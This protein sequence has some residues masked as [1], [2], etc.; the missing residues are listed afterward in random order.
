MNKRKMQKNQTVQMEKELQYRQNK[1]QLTRCEGDIYKAAMKLKPGIVEAERL[2]NHGEAI[3]QTRFYSSLMGIHDRVSKMI[4]QIEMI[5]S[6]DSIGNT[7]TAFMEDCKGIGSLE[8]IFDPTKL[9]AGQ[10]NLAKTMMQMDEV[11]E[12]GDMMLSSLMEPSSDDPADPEAERKLAELMRERA[13]TERRDQLQNDHRRALAD[14]NAKLNGR[15]QAAV[16][17]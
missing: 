14:T 3:R 12:R 1:R 17:G 9:M 16:N 8:G 2:G 7:L 6:L 5:H 13:A 15:M 11:L 4:M 10:E